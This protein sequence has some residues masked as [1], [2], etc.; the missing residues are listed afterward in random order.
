MAKKNDS[1]YKSIHSKYL[2]IGFF[3]LLLVLAFLVV[4]PFITLILA[5]A[6]VAY[7]LYPLFRGLRA[8][9]GIPWLS[10]T[11]CILLAIIIV[12]IPLLFITSQVVEESY[13]FYTN[14]MDD[15]E[16]DDSFLSCEGKDNIVCKGLNMLD[17][18]GNGSGFDMRESAMESLN[19]IAVKAINVVTGLIL[20]L[21]AV[22][23]QMFVMIFL[24]FFM[25]VDGEALIDNMKKLL[26]LSKN[27]QKTVTNTVSELIHATL[28][29]IIL[30]SVVQGI[31]AG[32]G[33]LIFGASSPF[34]W[35]VMAV[36]AA[37][38][39]FIGTALVW[40][41]IVLKMLITGWIVS[42]N[43]LIAR[44]VGLGL[45]CLLL[46]S[47][48]DNILKPKIIGDK[49]R[50]HPAIVLLGVFG[51]LA[52][53]GFIGIVIGPLLL[54]LFIAMLKIYELEKNRI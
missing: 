53:F 16:S 42:D 27:H 50:L 9:T 15:V 52:M 2:F 4:K 45:Y 41:P 23:F 54:A 19:S 37:F 40:V 1:D 20:G 32:I 28:Y 33:F 17:S 6:V 29:G 12:A 35:G 38:L 13:N 49:A 18:V 47:S 25:L 14:Y 51:G 39:P 36:I 5:S 31:L 10:A 22:L 46:V 44:A 34:L 24:L 21:P 43:S 11:I 26:P 7:V 30:V 48:I 8:K 3:L